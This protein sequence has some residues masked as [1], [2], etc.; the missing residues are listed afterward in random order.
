MVDIKLSGVQD[1][2]GE[3]LVEHYDRT[4]TLRTGHVCDSNWDKMRVDILCNSL[5]YET[6]LPTYGGYFTIDKNTNSDNNTRFVGR[7]FNCRGHERSLLDCQPQSAC[8][9]NDVRCLAQQGINVVDDEVCDAESI[10]GA[11]CGTE[12]E[13]INH[14]D[15]TLPCNTSIYEKSYVWNVYKLKEEIATV[16][17]MVFKNHPWSQ[18]IEVIPQ[19]DAKMSLFV[20]EAWR[21]NQSLRLNEPSG[22]WEH[23]ESSELLDNLLQL[24]RILESSL[25]TTS[26]KM[27][28]IS[29][30]SLAINREI[31]GSVRDAFNENTR[32]YQNKTEKITF[33]T[34]ENNLGRI[35]MMK[36]YM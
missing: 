16:E 15:Q 21:Q 4:G 10:A 26:M 35:A 9:Q 1:N 25:V 2:K 30:N 3:V 31:V 5:G 13:I 11:I 28:T 27:S 22:G 32:G 29:Y 24:S 20:I 23:L 36:S 18:Y 33:F 6:G 7:N 17:S 8:Q 14:L 34:K 12:I 19:I